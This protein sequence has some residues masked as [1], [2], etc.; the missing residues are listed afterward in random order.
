MHEFMNAIGV[1]NLIFMIP[2]IYALYRITSTDS[3]V[4]STIESQHEIIKMLSGRMTVLECR[5][6]EFNIELRLNELKD[7]A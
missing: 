7:K 3:S 1:V 5:L 4:M 6:N 2:I